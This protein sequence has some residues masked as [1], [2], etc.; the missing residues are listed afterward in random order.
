MAYQVIIEVVGS[1]SELLSFAKKVSKEGFA[2]ERFEPTPVDLCIEE[3]SFADDGFA[4]MHGDWKGVA[5]RDML[6]EPA[7]ALGYPFPL[8]SRE[9]VRE[10]FHALGE[11]GRRQLL[12]GDRLQKN[13][14]SH[15]AP[16]SRLWR[17]RAWG[18]E[19]ETECVVVSCSPDAVSIAFA[20]DAAVP[21]KILVAISKQYPALTFN[22]GVAADSAKRASSAVWIGGTRT[23]ERSEDPSALLRKVREFRQASS[24]PWLSSISG[25]L[26]AASLL[27]VAGDGRVVVRGTDTALVFLMSRLRQGLTGG[28]LAAKYSEVSSAHSKL[29]E[30]LSVAGYR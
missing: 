21:S 15:G 29:L 13:I 28:Q 2:F 27:E 10:C 6:R 20:L 25:G 14:D 17:K 11:V 23:A 18:T 12:L 3:G 8:Q 9:Q 19:H 1:E 30:A 22:V 4:A 5:A 16:N 24:L 7:K 26:D